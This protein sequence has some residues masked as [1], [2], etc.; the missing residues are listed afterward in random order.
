MPKTQDMQPEYGVRAR[1]LGPTDAGKALLLGLLLPSLIAAVLVIPDS[2]RRPFNTLGLPMVAIYLTRVKGLGLKKT[3]YLSR[4]WDPEFG[5]LALFSAGIMSLTALLSNVVNWLTKGGLAKWVEL[6]PIRHRPE[7][8]FVNLLIT[9][10]LVPITEELMFRGFM[11]S[12]FSGWG[13]GWAVIFPSILFAVVHLPLTM[14]GAFAMGVVAAI[15]VLRYRSL[16]P[17][18][19]M[20][21]VGNFLPVLTN[22]LVGLLGQPWGDVLGVGG[23][24]A[25]AVLVFVFRRK[26]MW[27]WQEFRCLWQE[28]AEKPQLGLRFRE[29][30]KQW[31]W[32]L[33]FIFIMINLVLIIVVPFIEV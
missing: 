17:A 33:L 20:H 3:F 30:I 9:V 6:L 25:V 8:L 18:V 22:Q 16:V 21:A 1:E 7:S 11:L 24:T 5:W 26:F 14:P 28:F 15:A 19:V 31:P 27:L 4:T 29:L 32:I 13:R 12:A 23:L 2:W 10:V